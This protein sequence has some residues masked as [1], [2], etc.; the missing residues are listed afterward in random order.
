MT[1]QHHLDKVLL[2]RVELLAD[3]NPLT[4]EIVENDGFFVF[5]AMVSSICALISLSHAI[6]D[7]SRFL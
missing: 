7:L 3:I 6:G 5:L 1:L 4:P 2:K